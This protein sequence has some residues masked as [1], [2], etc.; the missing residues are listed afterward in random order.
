VALRKLDKNMPDIE[1]PCKIAQLIPQKQIHMEIIEV[2]SLD[3]EE[4]IRNEGGFG[5]SGISK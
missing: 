3:E 2:D 1:L 5:S 4:T